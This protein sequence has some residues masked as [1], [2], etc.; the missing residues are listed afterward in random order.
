[1]TKHSTLINPDDLHYA[2]I[3]V[4]TGDP[5]GVVPDFIDQ[6]LTATDT[7][8][9]YRATGTIAG[10]MVELISPNPQTGGMAWELLDWGDY[11]GTIQLESRKKYIKQKAGDIVALLPVNPVIGDGLQLSNVSDNGF[12]Y[13]DSQGVAIRI[14]AGSSNTSPFDLYGD[15]QYRQYIYTDALICE[16]VFVGGVWRVFGGQLSYRQYTPPVFGCTDN[17]ATNYNPLATVDDGSCE[18]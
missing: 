6:I 17:A 1:M 8:K 14:D 9:V 15:P 4:F 13:L 5:N 18:Y 11:Q 7:N 12:L 10:G 16:L 2:K 3:R